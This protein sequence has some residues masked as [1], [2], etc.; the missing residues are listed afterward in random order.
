MARFWRMNGYNVFYPMGFDDNGLPTERLVEK[1]RHIR[2][3]ETDRNAFIAL[4]LEVSEQVEKDYKALWQRLGLSIDWQYTYRTI[5][6]LSRKTSQ[7]SF[8]DLYHKG[9]VYRKEAPAIWCP[10]CRTAIAQADL[11]DLDRP[12][13][14]F[15]LAFGREDGGILPVATTR[16][17]LLPA[18]VAVFVNPA[19][20]RY[21]SLVG[22]RLQVPL[23]GQKVPVIADKNADPE[24]GTGAVMCCTFGDQV[25]VE[26]WLTYQL[27]LL[28]ALGPD[29]KMTELAGRFSGLPFLEAR[30]G[31]IAEAQASE[32][33]I[34]RQPLS[35][36]VRVHERCD[37]PVEYR[38]TQ[39][40]FVKVLAF[41]P[42]L[43]TLGEKLTWHPAHMQ[44]RYREWVE[45]L[46]WDWCI[47][48]QRYFGVPFPIWYCAQCGQEIVADEGCLPVDPFES[49]P[50]ESCSCGS[51]EF[52]PEGDVMDTWMTSS[53][54]PQMA[55]RWLSD[56]ELYQMVFPF[57]LRPQAHEII[58]TWAFYTLVKSFHHFKQ[59]PW[60]EIAIS[61]WG[62][63]PQGKGKISKSKG[64]GP[65]A[66]LAMIERYSTDAVR[67]WA[68]SS[69]FGKDSIINEEKIQAGAHLVTKI[70][71][72]ARFVERS[73]EGHILQQEKLSLSPADRWILARLQTLI[74]EVTIYYKAYDYASARNEL[75]GFFWRDLADNYIEMVKQRLYSLSD[76]ESEGARF[77]LKSVFLS[78]IKMF[79]PIL[80]YVTEEIYQDLYAKYENARSIH[81]ATW[82]EVDPRFVDSQFES[83]GEVLV[84]IARA[85]RRY[86]SERNLALGSPLDRLQL[87]CTDPGLA[88]VLKTGIPDLASVTR[89]RM[90]EIVMTLDQNL[91]IV[92]AD[93]PVSI[94]IG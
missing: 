2:P 51:H 40:W 36:T 77:S 6:D 30:R 49:Q 94:A 62:L 5:D 26:W 73:T 15:T 8:L 76:K 11:D 43:I 44:A 66:P 50:A 17:E 23:F 55:G 12:V 48:R 4:C 57:T 24:K 56:P 14:F 28:V 45:N 1:W 83:L 71:N 37:T 61:G 39:Q 80:P 60:S 21:K 87:G 19:D 64:G 10:E 90:I 69:G 13:E 27:P 25:D 75:E 52:I 67:Y 81:Q 70:W 82:P 35:Q 65:E 7:K 9:L 42:E 34:T 72:V 31:M 54:S 85:V 68:S 32:L 16:P 78:V 93:G 18:C 74:K 89:A 46:H 79:A 88:E 29:G 86:K 63:A 59:L 84:N 92:S 47:S 53:M 22:S 20:A 3:A 41:K 33:L 91:E 58:R 38:V